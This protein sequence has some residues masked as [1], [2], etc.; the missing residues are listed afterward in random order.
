MRERKKQGGRKRWTDMERERDE[1]GA[2][3]GKESELER[4]SRRVWR[5]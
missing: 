5:I 3:G 1:R 4:E 2:D